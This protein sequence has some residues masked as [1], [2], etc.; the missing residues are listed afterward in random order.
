VAYAQEQLGTDTEALA[1]LYDRGL[2]DDTI[3][4]AG[5]GWNPADLWRE[6]ERWG[7]EPWTTPKGR[8]GRVWLPR[9]WVIPW[10]IGGDL[11]RV[12]IR[13]PQGQPKYIG[14]KGSSNGLYNGGSLAT[15]KAG[16]WPVAIVVEGEIDALTLGQVAGDLIT[17]VATGSTSGSRRPRW[18][19]RLALCPLVLVSFDAEVDKGDRAAA[20]WVGV[21]PNAKRWRPLWADANAMAQDGADLRGWVL[22]GLNDRPKQTKPDLG[23]R[24]DAVAAGAAG[25]DRRLGDLE[26]AHEVTSTV[27][28]LHVDALEV[29]ATGNP[30]H[31]EFARTSADWLAP[32]QAELPIGIEDLP[33]LKARYPGYAFRLT[34]PEG[35]AGLVLEV[36]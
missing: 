9:G 17:P 33:D 20:W 4:A 6:P 15:D 36:L 7:L 3:R 34:W 22:A 14:P 12:N 23:T 8:P 11:W 27:G 21:L 26:A 30:N 31:W 19:A 28:D 2:T 32:I 24:L 29:V 5:L 18:I 35:V 10:K 1:W 13:R 16:R 25:I